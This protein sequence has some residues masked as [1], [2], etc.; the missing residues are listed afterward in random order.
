VAL[1]E[2]VLPPLPVSV[3]VV[4]ESLVVGDPS[5]LLLSPPHAVENAKRPTNT[6]LASL[7]IRP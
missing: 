2:A 4:L 7:T 6:N 1:V 5:L 3:E